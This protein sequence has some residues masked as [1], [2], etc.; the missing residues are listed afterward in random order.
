MEHQF[1]A[2]SHVGDLRPSWRVTLQVNHRC[3]I[4]TP[5]A[6]E[7]DREIDSAE[8]AAKRKLSSRETFH[9]S[10]PEEDAMATFPE[11]TLAAIQAAPAYFDRDA[12]TEKAC[13]L[14]EQAPRKGATLAAFSETWLPGYRF[15][16]T[17]H[18]ALK[19]RRITW[20]MPWKFLARP[21]TA[22]AKLPVMQT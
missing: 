5:A 22:C 14:I 9:G 1:R 7:S 4:G 12:S 20:Q 15:V 3:D 19:R 16:I 6:F 8:V 21:R 11:F 13:G 17:L 10:N 2:V 18:A